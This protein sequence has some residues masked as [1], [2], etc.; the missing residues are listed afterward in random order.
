[1]IAKTSSLY[2][3]L[4]E[5][6]LRE[7]QRIEELRSWPGGAVVRQRAEQLIGIVRS[8]DQALVEQSNVDGVDMNS[9]PEIV[10]LKPA[11]GSEL[12]L[13]LGAQA[14]LAHY[15]LVRAESPKQASP[16]QHFAAYAKE[17]AQD[18]LLKRLACDEPM[19][20]PN[21]QHLSCNVEAHTLRID[22][23]QRGDRRETLLIQDGFL[24]YTPL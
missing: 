23:V 18:H 7:P 16:L 9:A 13:R 6:R 11:P 19:A 21:I 4:T 14:A 12:A 3:P 15:E 8:L 1:M 22:V 10:A 24:V 17:P 20:D 2:Q 5:F